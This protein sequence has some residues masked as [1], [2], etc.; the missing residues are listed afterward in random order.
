MRQSKFLR[1]FVFSAFAFPC[2]AMACPDGYYDTPLGMCFPNSGTVI[3]GAT[4]PFTESA[5]TVAGAAL[6]QWIVQSR[7][8][9]IG[10]SS[11][12]PP[13]V[14]YQLEPFFSREV[15]DRARWKVGDNGFFNAARAII[16]NGDVAAVT[17]ND[18]IVFRNYQDSQ[19]NVSLWAHELRHVQQYKEW[20]TRDFA[21]RYT[22]NF[23]AVEN[24]AYS[25]ENRVAS[26]PRRPAPYSSPQP[27][28]YAFFPP[29]R[30]SL[31]RACQ[32][33]V[34]WCYIP[35][36]YAPVGTICTCFSPYGPLPGSAF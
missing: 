10:S 21:I 36:A 16:S 25:M 20:G 2:A 23:N 32:T 4:R 14:R 35:P 30:V 31:V 9:A 19:N 5:V 29:P 8:S 18:L 11:P 27:P 13:L 6:E 24:E 26:S 33:R 7:N 1:Y 3:D 15:L 28:N 12:I 22:R 34:G 17:L